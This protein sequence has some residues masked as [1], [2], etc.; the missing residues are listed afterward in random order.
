MR[1]ATSRD[2]WWKKLGPGDAQRL[3]QGHM[4]NRVRL[5]PPRR[6]VGRARFFRDVFFGREGWHQTFDSYGNEIET[7]LVV[8][9]THIDGRHVGDRK[10]TVHYAEHRDERGR[11]TTDLLWDE[12]LPDVRAQ[13]F[14]GWYLLIERGPRTYR[15]SITRDEPA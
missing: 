6:V 10:L 11:P 14:S 15:L 7:A 9:D 2:T 8:F 3:S 5:T 13:D 12:L 1:M 4:T